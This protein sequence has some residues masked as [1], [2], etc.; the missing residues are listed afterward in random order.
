MNRAALGVARLALGAIALTASTTPPRAEPAAAPPAP[1]V[2]SPMQVE[3][4]GFNG[5][6]AGAGLALTVGRGPMASVGAARQ[7][8]SPLT[9]ALA[10]HLPRHGTAL[11][12]EDGGAFASAG[13]AFPSRDGL[14][15]R[16]RL[17]I[18]VDAPGGLHLAAACSD[19]GSE[20]LAARVA[21][22]GRVRLAAAAAVGREAQADD[23][24]RFDGS[25]AAVDTATGWSLAVAAAGE[26]RERAGVQRRV[27]VKL[28][29]GFAWRSA[30]E[31]V[32]GVDGGT[33]RYGTAAA[34]VLGVGARLR[35][36]ALDVF[37]AARWYQARDEGIDGHAEHVFT[38][39]ALRF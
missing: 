23:A 19:D 6:I 11:T 7:D 25:I 2:A 22:G 13:A 27:Y 24:W 21:R 15:E 30:G 34:S 16:H 18:D 26:E 17:R 20:D 4:N 39:G 3:L 10:P 1:F 28:A 14:G 5:R 37:A 9:I 32:L 29:R 12:A 36:K 8:W 38:G 35:G 33:A 31:L